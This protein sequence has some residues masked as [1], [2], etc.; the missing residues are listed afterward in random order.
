MIE[1]RNKDM[2][3]FVADIID[4]LRKNDI[5]ALLVKG[6]G[7]AQCYDKPFMVKSKDIKIVFI[8]G[9]G[10]DRDLG[11][12]T[13]FSKFASSSHWPSIP[14][15]VSPMYETLNENRQKSLW[16]DLEHFHD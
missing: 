1:Q 9:N 16:F 8:I 10:F 2:N 13:Q 3:A 5:Y 15:F 12:K 14:S 7:I 4:K 11:W 6:Q